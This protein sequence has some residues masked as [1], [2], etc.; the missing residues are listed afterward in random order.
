MDLQSCVAVPGAV[1][2]RHRWWFFYCLKWGVT[3]LLSWPRDSSYEKRQESP[4]VEE[5]IS[6]KVV[7]ASKADQLAVR[8]APL[9]AH[10]HQ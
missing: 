5:S 7:P 6:E 3:T 4:P 8:R 10:A 9:L 1:G 2:G